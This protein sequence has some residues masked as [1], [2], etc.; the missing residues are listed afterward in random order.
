LT[1]GDSISSKQQK[2]LMRDYTQA[3]ERRASLMTAYGLLMLINTSNVSISDI[4]C[5]ETKNSNFFFENLL[6]KLISPIPKKDKENKHSSH[7]AAMKRFS[8]LTNQS[9]GSSPK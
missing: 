7:V 9:Q 3:S 2:E 1:S 6:S 5:E 8:D 4:V